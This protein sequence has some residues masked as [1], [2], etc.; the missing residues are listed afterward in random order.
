MQIIPSDLKHGCS[1]RGGLEP[2]S[3]AGSSAN[4]QTSVA[5]QGTAQGPGGLQ[6]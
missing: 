5:T 3:D 2:K 4:R 1:V 6:F